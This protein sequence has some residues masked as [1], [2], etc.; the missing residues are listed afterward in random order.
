MARRRIYTRTTSVSF[1]EE[2][3]DLIKEITDRQETSISDFIRGAVLMRLRAT[4][5]DHDQAT[6]NQQKE[7][8]NER[9]K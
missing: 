6:T 3:Y 4:Q 9:E 8:E 1:T 7:Y 5:D 2:L